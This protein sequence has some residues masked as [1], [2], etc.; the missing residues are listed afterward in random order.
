[1]LKT[2]SPEVLSEWMGGKGQ[3]GENKFCIAVSL[4][5]RG[6][7]HREKSGWTG[8]VP[9]LKFANMSCLFIQTT[10]STGETTRP[11]KNQLKSLMV[12][13]VH[14]NGRIE[15]V[16]DLEFQKFHLCV[17]ACACW[18]YVVSFFWWKSRPT[19]KEARCL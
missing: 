14:G 9:R 6:V 18:T 4:S 17:C 1:M 19:A 12:F 2:S 13:R 16:A 3:H 15:Q 8:P 11:K 7:Q 5:D 10:S